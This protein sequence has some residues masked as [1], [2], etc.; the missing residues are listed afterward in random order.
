[1]KCVQN[2]LTKEIKRVSNE[3]AEELVGKGWNFVP[4]S[5]WK[6]APGTSHIAAT[7]ANPTKDY[8]LRR[9][10]KKRSTVPNPNKGPKT[11]KRKE[12]S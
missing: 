9:K 4:K 11:E 6:G 8:K 7:L 12:K 2:T 3:R 1:M 10:E 5:Q